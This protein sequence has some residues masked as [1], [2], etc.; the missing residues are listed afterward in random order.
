MSLRRGTLAS[1]PRDHRM[2]QPGSGYGQYSQGPYM[3]PPPKKPMGIGLILLI[4]LGTLLGT[5]PMCGVIGAASKKDTAAN[6]TATATTTPSRATAD[7]PTDT[8]AP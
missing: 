1:T 4:V 7:K 8:A 6:S 5:C 3:G 2:Q